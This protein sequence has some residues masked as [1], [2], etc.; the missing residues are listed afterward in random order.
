MTCSAT[1]RHCRS[2]LGPTTPSPQPTMGTENLR[3]GLHR[4]GRTDSYRRFV[5]LSFP[6]AHVECGAWVIRS[7]RRG[8]SD[9]TIWWILRRCSTAAGTPRCWCSP[10]ARAGPVRR[11]LAD[12]RQ[13]ASLR[14]HGNRWRSADGHRG[15][16][17]GRAGRGG[18]WPEVSDVAAEGGR[19]GLLRDRD[20]DENEAVWVLPYLFVGPGFS[21]A[22]GYR[23]SHPCGGRARSTRRCPG[24]SR[25]GP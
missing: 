20:R 21:R 14:G 22:G 25:V 7:S 2:G 13:P 16:G 5:A 10:S 19:T 15:V 24:L 6:P 11:R 3:C 1:S 9:E 4:A 23:C 8:P 17:V 18:L 12:R